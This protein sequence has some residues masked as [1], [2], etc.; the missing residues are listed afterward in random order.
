MSDTRHK[1]EVLACVLMVL[2]VIGVTVFAAREF[3]TV[4]R[5][6]AYG[7][8]VEPPDDDAEYARVL[9]KVRSLVDENRR[10]KERLKTI[11]T[12]ARCA[13][14]PFVVWEKDGNN[15]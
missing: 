5:E 14:K 9:A 10:L 4:D 3:L 12:L 13:D 15:E 1:V 11:E 7:M 6:N 2:L 8:S